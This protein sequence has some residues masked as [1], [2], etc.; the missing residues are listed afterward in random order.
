MAKGKQ[1]R[2]HELKPKKTV[3]A[4]VAAAKQHVNSVNAVSKRKGN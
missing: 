1:P 2:I 3:G 4:A